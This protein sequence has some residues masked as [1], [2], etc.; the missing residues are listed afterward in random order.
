MY[1]IPN[2]RDAIGT[3]QQLATLKALLRQRMWP[4]QVASSHKDALHP[5]L[6]TPYG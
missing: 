1:V 3:H 5:Q 4:K 6:T 2:P